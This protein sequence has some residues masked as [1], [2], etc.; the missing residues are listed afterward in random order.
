[1][2][3]ELLT[4]PQRPS[5]KRGM[6]VCKILQQVSLY[7][8][9]FSLLLLPLEM[10]FPCYLPVP[11]ARCT[12]GCGGGCRPARRAARREFF[13]ENVFVRS[14]PD[15]PAAFAA[16]FRYSLF[17]RNIYYSVDLYNLS[18]CQSS[19]SLTIGLL[20]FPPF[21]NK[22]VRFYTLQL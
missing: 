11:L 13:H 6:S 7:A 14:D 15:I 12:H 2:Y 21:R 4:L 3:P 22:F 9:I 18:T 1:M 8:Q 16:E 20:S 10:G 19:T 17:V 5:D